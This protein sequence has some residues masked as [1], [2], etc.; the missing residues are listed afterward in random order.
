MQKH[1]EVI[2]SF[3]F[4]PGLNFGRSE[5]FKKAQTTEKKTFFLDGAFLRDYMILWRIRKN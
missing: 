3:D 4:E 2:E 1:Y 5:N